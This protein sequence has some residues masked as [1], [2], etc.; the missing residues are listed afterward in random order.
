M[1]PTSPITAQDS[2]HAQQVGHL[3]LFSCAYQGS[4]GSSRESEIECSVNDVYVPQA[5]NDSRWDYGEP[6]ALG[7]KER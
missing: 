4:S 5:G 2:D 6:Q 7:V 3:H 1:V